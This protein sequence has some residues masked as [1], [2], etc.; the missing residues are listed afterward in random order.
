MSL[1]NENNANIV[2]L[3]VGT[4]AD[5]V[6]LWGMNTG[7]RKRRIKSVKLMNNATL[8]GDDTNNVVVSLQNGAT[9]LASHTNDVESGGLTAQVAKEMV[10]NADA[11]L[12]DL[13][14]D[15]DLT[16]VMADTG[17][18]QNLTLAQIQVELHA[19]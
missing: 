19:L 18:G 15:L 17:T 11:S 6:T 7:K 3:E 2:L 14:K 13:G 12:L 8:A 5:A 1:S 16:I 9:V 4:Q 10:L